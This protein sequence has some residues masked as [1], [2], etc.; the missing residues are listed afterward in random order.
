MCMIVVLT[1]VHITTV[2]QSLGT[3]VCMNVYL[4]NVHILY[5]TDYLAFISYLEFYKQFNT[6][7]IYVY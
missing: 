7:L 5:S 3:F 2:W 4:P 6:T 1:F